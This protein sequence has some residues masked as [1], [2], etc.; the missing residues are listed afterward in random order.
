MPPQTYC[1][2]S[3][4]AA[5]TGTYAAQTDQIPVSSARRAQQGRRPSQGA[6]H[7]SS[8]I[9][10]AAATLGIPKVCHEMG[11]EGAPRAH[12]HPVQ[13]HGSARGIGGLMGGAGGGRSL[14]SHTYRVP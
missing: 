2:S 3:I 1:Q 5:Q 13:S 7:M 11:Y 9:H 10:L 6:T 4:A 14:L 8:P 12:V